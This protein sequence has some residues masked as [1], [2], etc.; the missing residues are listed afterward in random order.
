MG[1]TGKAR[2]PSKKKPKNGTGGT[3]RLIALQIDELGLCPFHWFFSR[4]STSTNSRTVTSPA[5]GHRP[6]LQGLVDCLKVPL[7]PFGERFFTSSIAFSRAFSSLAAFFGSCSRISRQPPSF[8]S[9][10]FR[11]VDW[12][13]QNCSC[14]LP[15]GVRFVHGH[16]TRRQ[17]LVDGQDSVHLFLT[18]QGPP[19]S[20]ADTILENSAAADSCW[21]SG[22]I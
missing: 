10:T 22:Q 2:I 4:L 16:Q 13:V 5:E 14:V 17:I 11:P 6:A 8:C 18:G 7:H 20:V 9:V 15:L 1:E 19:F 3:L 12:V 21:P